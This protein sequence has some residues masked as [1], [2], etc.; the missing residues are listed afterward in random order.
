[1]NEYNKLLIWYTEADIRL[2]L[3][4]ARRAM[5]ESRTKE[6]YFTERSEDFFPHD[7]VI[8]AICQAIKD[9]AP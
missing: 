3:S 5:R 2:A 6:E 8:D 4:Y 9:H 7:W 1:M